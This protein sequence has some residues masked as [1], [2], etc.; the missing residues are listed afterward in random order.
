MMK[1]S[2]K[3]FT[4]AL[5]ISILVFPYSKVLAAS[6]AQTLAELRK[7]LQAYK[8]KKASAESKKK[9][10]QAEI[11]TAK[12]NV[13]NKQ[14]EINQNRQKVN[15]AIS[16]SERLTKEIADGKAELEKLMKNYQVASGDNVYLEYIFDATSYEDLIYRYAVMEQIMNY[17]EGR[18]NTWKDKIE[19]NNQLKT[20]LAAREITLNSQIKSLATDIENLNDALEDYFDISLSAEE[21]IKSTQKLITEYEKMGCKENQDL[22]ECI[23]LYYG[24]YGDTR[25]I[26]PLNKGTITSVWG[27]RTHPTTG[28]ANTFHN[29]VDIGGNKVGTAVYSS[30]NGM[31]GKIIY[32][33][34]CGG[35]QV[36]I[37]HNI[38]GKK[39]TTS[40]LHLNS[41]NVKLGQV[42]KNN[43]VIGTVGGQKGTG[44]TCTTGAHLHFGLG[45]GWYGSDYTS[46]STWKARS[47][48]PAS[49]I[50]FPAK[51]KSFSSRN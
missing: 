18:I 28:V 44:D 48:N 22:Q 14:N 46:S 6:D 11:N 30:A 25:L 32:K 3:I 12:A 42:V 45:S 37:Y 13:S 26:R 7:D 34:S 27:Y 47:I 9:S 51:N 10:T 19:Y 36:Y 15:D 29:G 4:I 1:K 23:Y 16:E 31:V 35:N 33:S 50:P 38:N 2:F 17:Q 5:V 41:I 8:N 40:Y 43:T 20:D 39:Y 24:A 21:D 49:L